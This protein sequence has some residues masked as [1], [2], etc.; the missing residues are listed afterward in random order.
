MSSFSMFIFLPPY[1]QTALGVPL[2]WRE[3]SR[4]VVCEICLLSPDLHFTGGQTGKI[5][6]APHIPNGPPF[7]DGVKGRPSR[8]VVSNHLRRVPRTISGDGHV[9]RGS[10]VS[11]PHRSETVGR[12]AGRLIRKSAPRYM[13]SINTYLEL[14]LLLLLF[15]DVITMHR[16]H[17][18]GSGQGVI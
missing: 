15:C 6:A 13:Y 7:Q 14:L 16:L 1:A 5:C 11:A 12:V 3:R 2:C 9:F 10:A 18:E 17:A 4:R 8:A